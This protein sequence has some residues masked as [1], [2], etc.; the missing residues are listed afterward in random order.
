MRIPLIIFVGLA[1][2][3]STSFLAGLRPLGIVPNL[4][5]IV[6][7]ICVLHFPASWVTAL[8][9]VFGL[10]MDLSSGSDFGLRMG[11]YSMYAMSVIILGRLGADYANW[12]IVV[13]TLAGGT[14]L[15]NAAI[16]GGMALRGAPMDFATIGSRIVIELGV[17]MV[18]AVLVKWPLTS[19]LGYFSSPE[20][21]ISG[22][23]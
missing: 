3:L 14:I 5:L 10:M 11:F 16:L 12:G 22:S 7:I 15:F 18:I 17:N 20:M 1:T 6:I 19:L 13:V 23:R 21:K 4:M 2:Y 9:L 8:A